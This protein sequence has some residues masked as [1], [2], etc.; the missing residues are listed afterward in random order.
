MVNRF[1]E[2]SHCN[3]IAW[4]DDDY[5]EY[6]RCCL[7]VDPVESVSSLSYDYVLI[8]TVDDLMAEQ[9]ERRLM[10]LGV[11]QRKILK[12]VVPQ[13]KEELLTRFLDVDAIRAGE[14]RRKRGIT[15]HA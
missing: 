12:T 3:V 15:S 1:K 11:S 13:E 2:T 8:A 7:D 4:I 10:D 14:A 5:W 6:R 9:V